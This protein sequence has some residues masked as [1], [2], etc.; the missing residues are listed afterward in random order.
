[1]GVVPAPASTPEAGP[2]VL[3]A[4]MI[5]HHP[6]ISATHVHNATKQV[7]IG[8]SMEAVPRFWGNSVE[9][10][11]LGLRVVTFGHVNEVYTMNVPSLCFRGIV[12]I[13]KQFTEWCNEVVISCEQRFVLASRPPGSL[14]R[15]NV[16]GDGSGVVCAPFAAAWAVRVS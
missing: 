6:P 4:E 12:G 9:V 8:G 7:T 5:S 16:T 2:T 14:I 15:V 13:G 1:V 11:F 10:E 3:L